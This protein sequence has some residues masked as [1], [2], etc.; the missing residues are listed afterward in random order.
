M[1]A[2]WVPLPLRR[3]AAPLRPMSAQSTDLV[4]S[5][6]RKKKHTSSRTKSRSEE[7][8]FDPRVLPQLV[9]LALCQRLGFRF[10]FAESQHPCA[11]C[12]HNQQI[13]SPRT[14][15]KKKH[16]SSR[17]KS[18]SEESLFDPRVLPQLVALA[19]CQRLGFRFLFA[20]SQHPCAPC[21]H[22]QQIL[23]PRT[24]AKKNP[25]HSERCPL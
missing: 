13:L 20:E 1:P 23:S 4:P 21:P 6:L 22:N 25:R 24:Y 17:T 16:T 10:L 14:Y 18:R 19:L 7:S 2:S 5:Y 11:P 9:A 3:V 12:P 15:A 8:L